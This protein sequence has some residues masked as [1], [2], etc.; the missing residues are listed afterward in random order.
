MRKSRVETVDV[1]TALCGK[2]MGFRSQVALRTEFYVSGMGVIWIFP[3]I[4]GGRDLV[5]SSPV[6]VGSFGQARFGDAFNHFRGICVWMG[7]LADQIFCLP[8]LNPLV[9]FDIYYLGSGG[10]TWLTILFV[11]QRGMIPGRFEL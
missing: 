7:S 9:R 1:V 2:R 3:Q 11:P 10:A 4:P 6:R 5:A 8:I